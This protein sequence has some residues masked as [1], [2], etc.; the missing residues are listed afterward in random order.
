MSNQEVGC[1]IK[2]MAYCW[3]E[4]SIPADIA[5]IAKL[6]GEDS[7]A[8]AQLWLSIKQCFVLANGSHDRLTHPRLEKE[9]EK[10]SDFKRERAESGKKGAAARWDKAKKDGAANGSA[11]AEG[12]A[13]DGSSSSSASSM[14]SPSEKK[15]RIP[16]FDARGF[17]LANGASEKTVDAWLEIRKGKRLKQ[18]DVAMEGTVEEAKKAGM[19]LEAALQLCCKRG[20]GGFDAA[21]VSGRSPP[22]N[23]QDRNDA[24]IA[25]LT[26][27]DRSYEPD[28]RIIDV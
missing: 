21:W 18:T 20:W 27:R 22:S 5:K 2:L 26:G 3:R 25:A 24:T 19:T 28:D 13:P 15:Q 16:R 12:M 8:M 1:Y 17:L 11:M 7:S 6:C 10:Q 14:S 23:F 9:R 4:G